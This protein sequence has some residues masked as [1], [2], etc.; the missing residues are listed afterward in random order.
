M[1]HREAFPNFTDCCIFACSE[2]II[3]RI[4]FIV[5]PLAGLYL[6]AGQHPV[7]EEAVLARVSREGLVL[8]LKVGSIAQ[9]VHGVVTRLLLIHRN[10]ARSAIIGK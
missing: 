1:W 3:C 7:A 6:G 4:K 2:R 9:M 5:R 8:L 10:Y